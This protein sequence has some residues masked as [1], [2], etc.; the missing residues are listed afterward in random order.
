MDIEAVGS[1]IF[2]PHTSE[3]MNFLHD[4]W[5]SSFYKGC[6]SHKLLSPDEFHSFHRPIRERFFSKSNTCV[7]VAAPDNNPWQILGWIA[8]EQIPSGLILQYLYMKSALK[9]EGLSKELIKRALPSS[10]VFYTHLTDRASRILASKYD[11]FQGFHYIP[12]LI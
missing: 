3:D 5:G 1:V 10:P 7:I 4:S 6:K 11:Q 9:G 12:T 8:V 2:R